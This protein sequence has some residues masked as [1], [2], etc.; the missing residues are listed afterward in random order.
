MRLRCAPSALG[1]ASALVLGLTAAVPSTGAA[2][3]PGIDR[4]SASAARAA[5]GTTAAGTTT[6]GTTTTGTTTTG[7]R[8]AGTTT[9]GVASYQ[10][11]V[12][13]PFPRTAPQQC[14]VLVAGVRPDTN[15]VGFRY[16]KGRV[17]AEVAGKIG[18]V[19]RTMTTV[20]DLKAA[21]TVFW[22][23]RQD[24][25]LYRITVVADDGGVRV[26]AKRI[27]AG[28]GEIRVLA[29][30]SPT[31]DSGVTY[32]YGL[33]MS[34]GLKRYV[35]SPDGMRL[36]S[37]KTI[38]TRGW[39]DVRTLSFDR[40]QLTGPRARPREADVMLA[41]TRRGYLAEFFFPR[42]A[43]LMWSRTNLRT[44]TWQTFAAVNS[45]FCDSDRP[46]RPIMAVKPD[47]A[48]YLYVDQNGNDRWGGDI[49][50]ALKVATWSG[51][52]LYNQ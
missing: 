26:A 48:A 15:L 41:A 38:A 13:G 32:L 45:G 6:A 43:Y 34:G 30:G 9:A 25:M 40:V 24:G 36:L 12:F 27:A 16:E 10:R 39:A 51:A 52:K 14:S 3:S 7:R 35:T 5:A 44:S 4:I 46:S 1:L 11:R 20:T 22:A 2:G 23:I 50:R 33:T 29:A 19:P 18:W 37:A 49:G 31:G 47:G 42:T 21:S 28:W 8:T 17:D